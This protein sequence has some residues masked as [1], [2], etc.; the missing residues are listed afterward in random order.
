MKSRD[1]NS[2]PVDEL[3]ALHLKVKSALASRIAE[4]KTKLENLLKQ[5]E[6]D[7]IEA[8]P[9]TSDR[10]RPYPRVLPKYRNP[11]DPKETWAGR[12]KQPRWLT[13]QLKSGKKLEEFQIRQSSG[14]ARVAAKR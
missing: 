11:S 5:L 8:L 14:R 4:E 10:R 7:G 12:G 13:A 9:R 6:A 2:I 3:W 1:F